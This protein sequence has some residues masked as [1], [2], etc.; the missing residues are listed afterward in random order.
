M[1]VRA[2]HNAVKQR[3][4]RVV[5]VNVGDARWAREVKPMHTG[6]RGT[7]QCCACG[8]LFKYVQLMDFGTYAGGTHSKTIHA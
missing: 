2:S 6:L 3:V 1:K 8:L 5:W 7:K 4:K